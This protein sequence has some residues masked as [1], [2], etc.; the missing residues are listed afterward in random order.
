MQYLFSVPPKIDIFTF[1]Q[2]C[3]APGH[4][5]AALQTELPRDL[6]RGEHGG[7]APGTQPLQPGGG[8]LHEG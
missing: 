2:F 3:L 4:S 5:A 6:P 7:G 8:C 1:S